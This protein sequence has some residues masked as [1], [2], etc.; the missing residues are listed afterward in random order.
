MIEERKGK[1]GTGFR[2]VIYG[3]GGIRLQKTFPSKTLAKEWERRVLRER[4]EQEATGIV[5]N[6]KVSFEEF[7]ERWL[8]EKVNVRCSNSTKVN[9]ERVVR[10]HLTPIMGKLKMKDI[11]VEHGN[12]LVAA[13]S[14]EGYAP[15]GINVIVG[16]LLTLL[17]DAVHWQV[18]IRNPLFRF[19]PVREPDIHYNFWSRAEIDHFLLQSV[20]DP[21]H[22]VYV[23]ALNTGMRRGEICGL[24]W[25]RVDF[26]SGHIIVNRTLDRFGLNETTKSGKTRIIPMNAVLKNMLERLRSTRRSDFVFCERDGS[27]VDAHHLYR[28]FQRSQANA[29]FPK[30]IRFHDLR[31]T[32]ASHFMMNGGNCY[33]LQKL[34]GHST[35]EMTQRYAH[36]SPAHLA[37]AIQ[38]VSF[39]AN[40][41]SVSSLEEARKLKLSAMNR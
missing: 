8:N 39:S 25:D 40:A 4:T 33:D 14:K 9:Y 17:N 41:G 19:K 10:I 30:L 38:I 32:F 36:L 20:N 7:A 23:V 1:G 13:L 11:R 31:H 16:V 24:K 34:L 5:V 12:R 27:P 28:A 3:A 6:D 15:K 26:V 29:G 35:Q 37:N 21:L 22:D 2:A 18:L